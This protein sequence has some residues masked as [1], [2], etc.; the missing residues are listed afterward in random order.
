MGKR[1]T[2]GKPVRMLQLALPELAQGTVALERGD[3][4]LGAAAAG[5]RQFGFG[6]T[7]PCGAGG[8]G[9]MV[10]SHPPRCG[11]LFVG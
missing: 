11:G 8:G 6:T 5:R 4:L 3:G 10:Q 1:A 2:Q 7:E 9:H